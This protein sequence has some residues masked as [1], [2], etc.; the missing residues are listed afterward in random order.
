MPKWIRF[1]TSVAGARFSYKPGDLVE[2]P[3]SNEAQ[4]FVDREYATFEE[5]PRSAPSKTI[6]TTSLSPDG[7]SGGGKGRKP[8]T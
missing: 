7:K 2:W 4:R 6:E 1:K 5:P 8:S 3:D